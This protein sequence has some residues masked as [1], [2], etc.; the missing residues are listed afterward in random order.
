M[1]NPWKLATLTLCA[2]NGIALGLG[3]WATQT[4]SGQQFTAEQI[5]RGVR[6][7]ISQ[8]PVYYA[9]TGLDGEWSWFGKGCYVVRTDQVEIVANDLGLMTREWLPFSIIKDSV[10]HSGA[11]FI[12]SKANIS[13]CLSQLPPLYVMGD[14]DSAPIPT[15]D[16]DLWQKDRGFRTGRLN[17]GRLA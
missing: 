10:Q 6:F 13:F 4:D 11:Q 9:R 5:S 2:L 16:P 12:L 14:A 7:N 15:Y 8:R 1:M 3:V 17:R